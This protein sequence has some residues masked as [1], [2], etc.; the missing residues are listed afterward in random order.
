MNPISI[1]YNWLKAHPNV[2]A[3]IV[4]L[5]VFLLGFGTA[6]YTHPAKIVEHTKIQTVTKTDIQYK[7]RIV[8][9]KVYVQAEK[10]HTHTETTTVKKPDGTAETKVVTDENVDESKSNNTNTTDNKQEV[11]TQVVTQ[12]ITKDKLVLNQPDWRLGAGVGYSFATLGGAPQIGLPGMKGLVVQVQ[13]DRRI[14]GPVFVGLSLNTQWTAFIN[15][16]AAF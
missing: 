8:T 3:T 16:S 7:D 6:F 10:K 13:A 14:L 5:L 2:R 1:A 4:I 15:V 12:T 11:V 9:Q